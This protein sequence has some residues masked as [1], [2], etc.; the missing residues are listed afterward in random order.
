MDQVKGPDADSERV[1]NP[2]LYGRSLGQQFMV[3]QFAKVELSRLMYIENHQKEL[4]A[5]IYSGAKD[6]MKSD[7]KGLSEVGKKVILPSS[8]TSGSRYMHQQYLDAIALYQRYGHPHLFITMTCNPFWPEIQENLKEGETALDRPDLVARVFK[9]KKQQLIKDLASEMI[10]GK[11]N[12]RTHSIEFQK[13]GF[14]HM[15]I[16]CWFA[17]RTHLT[18]EELDRIISAEI[19]DEEIEVE[20]VNE[21]TKE[22]YTTTIKNPLYQA[23]IDFML[24]GPCGTFNKDRSC[25]KDGFCRYNFPKDYQSRTEMSEDGYPMYRRRSPEKGGNSYST[26]RNNR[27]HTFTNADVVPYNKYL[28]YKNNCHINVEYCHSV[29]AIKY[30][31]IHQQRIGCGYFLC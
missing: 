21:E 20:L 23:V 11:L 31:L 24:H 8:F 2:I 9:L 3:D 22:K 19:P 29:K 13:R 28:L 14:P 12:A 10:Y 16:I 26:F 1:V 17:G 4:R 30:H 5:E 25:M 6:A 7:G 18:E 27:K 15:H